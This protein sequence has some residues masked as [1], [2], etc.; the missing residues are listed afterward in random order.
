MQQVNANMARSEMKIKTILAFIYSAWLKNLVTWQERSPKRTLLREAHRYF[1]LVTC[2][3]ICAFPDTSLLFLHLY[4]PWSGLIFCFELQAD[5]SLL[6]SWRG[7]GT[8]PTQLLFA[9][10]LQG[11]IFPNERALWQLHWHDA[12]YAD[13][14]RSILE[15]NCGTWV[16]LLFRLSLRSGTRQIPPMSHCRPKQKVCS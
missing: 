4:L 15:T 10:C 3:F 11:I 5:F 8:I 2:L 1:K 6:T 13:W 14:S 7:S 12:F 9:L 16:F